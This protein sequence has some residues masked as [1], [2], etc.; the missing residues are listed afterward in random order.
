MKARLKS[1]N[2]SKKW[3]FLGL[4]GGCLERGSPFLLGK[5]YEARKKANASV[6]EI[7]AEAVE[8][9]RLAAAKSDSVK[10]KIAEEINSA[11]QRSSAEL[12]KIEEELQQK[13]QAIKR[14][15]EQTGLG[16]KESKDAV[17][18]RAAAIGHRG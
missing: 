2:A 17:E 16:L 3:H 4:L 5:I 12:S 9:I 6:Q 18:A 14:Y 13:I 1:V 15:R 11:K 7:N 10:M 8:K